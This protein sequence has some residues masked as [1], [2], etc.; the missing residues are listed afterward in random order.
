[1]ALLSDMRLLAQS[2]LKDHN[3]RMD[4]VADLRTNVRQELNDYRTA[5]QS[6]AFEQN[7]ALNQHMAAL[8][9]EVVEASLAT[10]I[11]LDEMDEKQRMMSALQRQTL[12]EHIASLRSQVANASQATDD[13]L[14]EINRDH[15]TL[16]NEQRQH[17]TEQMDHLH[18]QVNDLRQAAA[19]FLGDL[20]K[21]NQS[22]ADELSTK[23]TWQRS[24][25]AQDTT[26]FINTVSSAHKEMAQQQAQELSD[27]SEKLHQSV[28]ELRQSAAAFLKATDYAHQYMATTQKHNMLHNRN[29]LAVTVTMMRKRLQTEQHA[30]RTDQAEAAKVWA[31][32]VRL[33]QQH[34]PKKVAAVYQHEQAVENAWTESSPAEPHD[35]ADDLKVIHG[36]GN[37]MAQRL[38]NAGI[39]TFKQLAGSTPEEIYTILGNIGKL[40]KVEAWIAQAQNLI[41]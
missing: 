34:R 31:N 7:K 21:S 4:A 29:K 36:I 12:G 15:Q 32:I 24:R 27:Q 2:I 14:K 20:D 19:D 10:T 17:L 1:M 39:T 35:A 6:L 26:N 18:H 11:F 25:L 13:F 33:K 28:Q 9:R 38:N 23:L 40:A 16:T 22:M 3:A 5:H 8:R 41:Q 37:V 30:L